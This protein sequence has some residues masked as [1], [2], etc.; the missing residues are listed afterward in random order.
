MNVASRLEGLCKQ[1]GVDAIVS[2][3]VVQ[4]I[5]S[6]FVFRRLDCVAVK[7]RTSRLWVYELLGAAGDAIGE[8]VVVAK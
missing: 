5:G 1:Y 3:S 7:G 8:R 2:E 6:A 4:A